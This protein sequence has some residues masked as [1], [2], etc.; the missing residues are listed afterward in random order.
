MYRP[1]LSWIVFVLIGGAMGYLRYGNYLPPDQ[2]ALFAKYGPWIVIAIHVIVTLMAFSD[3]VF[4]GILC[5]LIPFYSF[6]YLF[7]VS[8]AFMIRAVAAGLLVGIAQDSI[9]VFQREANRIITAVNQW[10]SA[11]GEWRLPEK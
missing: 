2:L 5:L 6:Y 4:Q 9:L 11:G 10:I 3:T 8:D 1:V 7:F